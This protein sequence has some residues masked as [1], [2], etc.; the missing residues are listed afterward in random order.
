MTVR[1]APIG[2]HK[3]VLII[4]LNSTQ[5]S[6]M[7]SHF[8]KNWNMKSYILAS[9]YYDKKIPLPML[10]TKWD[11]LKCW[12][13]ELM[14][15][16]DIGTTNLVA[17]SLYEWLFTLC[18]WLLNAKNLPTTS[19]ICHQHRSPTFNIA[20]FSIWGHFPKIKMSLDVTSAIL[21]QFC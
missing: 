12:W 20:W 3:S 19:Q 14:M 21:D 1:P 10:R 15:A 6:F 9:K 16:T 4:Q 11:L 18:W 7:S 13:R 5:Y 17:K 2:G 8:R